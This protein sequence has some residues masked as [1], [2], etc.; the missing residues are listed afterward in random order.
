MFIPLYAE[1]QKQTSGYDDIELIVEEDAKQISIGEKRN[2]LLARAKGEWI[3]YFDSDD[4][5]FE[6]YVNE[7][8]EVLE[9]TTEPIDCI[10]INI[11]MTTNNNNLQRCCHSLR[12][13]K[14][15]GDGK[16][17]ID[18]WDYVRNIT[19]FN[20]VKREL[21]LQTGFKPIRF[22]EDRDYSDRLYP[23]LKSEYYI[24]YPLFHYRYSNTM[25]DAIKYG[26]KRGLFQQN[27][28]VR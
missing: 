16:T 15:Q 5:P 20:P 13:P 7:I 28:R 25:P 26:Y 22:G 18:G 1:F 2:K 23:L 19:H 24:P 6:Y 3:V 27:I 8:M 14:W 10:G 9:R 17:K 4:F 11:L 21:A 12:Y